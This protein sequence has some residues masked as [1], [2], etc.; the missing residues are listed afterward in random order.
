MANSWLKVTPSQGRSRRLSGGSQQQRE[1]TVGT[2]VQN[3]PQEFAST[4]SLLREFPSTGRRGWR[5]SSQHL[6]RQV[7]VQAASAGPDF[8][9][10]QCLIQQE[11]IEPRWRWQRLV[12]PLHLVVGELIPVATWRKFKSTTLSVRW[13]RMCL[14]VS[15][16]SAQCWD[17]ETQELHLLSLLSL[18]L[19]P[20][21]FCDG[22][23]NQMLASSLETCSHLHWGHT[24]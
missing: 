8:R 3:L 5:G 17:A 12:S 14:Q 4:A 16:P 20:A 21:H 7:Q 19:T 22:S 11:A 6:L 2:A 15:Q 18:S 13:Q 10:R 24:E 1:G 23:T 9:R